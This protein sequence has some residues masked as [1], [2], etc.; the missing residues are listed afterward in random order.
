MC[1][2]NRGRLR[3]SRTPSIQVP[4]GFDYSPR[5]RS[6][7]VILMEWFLNLTV[8]VPLAIYLVAQMQ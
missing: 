8:R 3:N 6:A 1:S 4:G 2:P 7:K 5:S